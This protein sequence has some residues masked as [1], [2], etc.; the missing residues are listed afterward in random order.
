MIENR[1][2]QTSQNILFLFN[3]FNFDNIYIKCQQY[4]CM[5]KANP[6]LLANTPTPDLVQYHLELYP[7]MPVAFVVG[8]TGLRSRVYPCSIIQV[9]RCT[10]TK[11][12]RIKFAFSC[13][14]RRNLPVLY[15][16]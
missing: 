2:F 4:W 6:I 15:F 11:A 1:V 12:R 13:T 14:Y 9:R 7:I 3:L 5:F 8:S 16:K 10:P